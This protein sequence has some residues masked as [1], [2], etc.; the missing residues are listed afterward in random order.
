MKHTIRDTMKVENKSFH[1]QTYRTEDGVYFHF[2]PGEVKEIPT[3][4]VSIISGEPILK[5]TNL[6]IIEKLPDLLEVDDS[7]ENRWGILDL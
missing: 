5:H 2:E 7:I 6:K 1:H 4:Y 3:K